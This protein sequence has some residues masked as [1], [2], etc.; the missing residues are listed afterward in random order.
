MVERGYGGNR[1]DAN[2]GAAHVGHLE[3]F[4]DRASRAEIVQGA[5]RKGVC[6]AV[7]VVQQEVLQLRP[8]AG[9]RLDVHVL[10]IWV[11]LFGVEAE[12]TDLV[13]RLQD[14][15]ED[16]AESNAAAPMLLRTKEEQVEASEA[17][18]HGVAES[19]EGGY[20]FVHRLDERMHVERH[21]L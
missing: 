17:G 15:C 14:G 9:G 16:V 20:R 8:R 12:V 5:K 21:R 1:V 19:R 7:V 3:L 4:E 2:H 13:E 18:G 6:K 11:E 10:D